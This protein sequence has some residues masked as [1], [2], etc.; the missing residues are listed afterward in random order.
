VTNKWR[1]REYPTGWTFQTLKQMTDQIVPFVTPALPCWSLMCWFT[2][3][4]PLLPWITLGSSLHRQCVKTSKRLFER[5]CTLSCERKG[6]ALFQKAVTLFVMDGGTKPRSTSRQVMVFRFSDT[7]WFASSMICQESL[8]WELA[9]KPTASPCN[10]HHTSQIAWYSYRK[11]DW[12]SANRSN[13]FIPRR[14]FD[15]YRF[16]S[17]PCI[18]VRYRRINP[19]PIS[20]DWFFVRASWSSCWSCLKRVFD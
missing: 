14:P 18:R 17:G 19:H 6:Q 11:R 13:R 12:N 9:A 16:D 2:D 10:L 8:Q 3:Y 5:S 4:F 1:L 7:M 20:I 15:A